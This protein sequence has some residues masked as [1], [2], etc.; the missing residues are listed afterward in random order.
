MNVPGEMAVK[1][2]QQITGQVHACNPAHRCNIGAGGCRFKTWREPSSSPKQP[3]VW[4]SIC[5]ASLQ[6]HMC[7]VG[8]CTEPG[9]QAPN[10]TTV[11]PISSLELQGPNEM[12]YAARTSG[13]G[14]TAKPFSHCMSS[15]DAPRKRRRVADGEPTRAALHSLLF[16]KQAV[17]L[18]Q[19]KRARGVVSVASCVRA[20][21]P[22]FM[23]QMVAARTQHP[24]MRAHQSHVFRLVKMLATDLHQYISRLRDRLGACKG[25]NALVAACVSY[26]STGLTCRG[27]AII[28]RLKWL[29]D[30][31]PH[32]SDYGKIDGFQSRPLSVASRC[33]K[34][35]VSGLR[36][37]P[38]STF[39]FYPR[40]V[41][42]SDARL[43]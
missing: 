41:L 32:P 39:C 38:D 40:L 25:H 28:P 26:L 3:A 14:S 16:S 29:K 7:G 27:V 30:L 15:M 22:S 42:P 31:A 23:A 10:G 5:Y 20:A 37:H 2:M 35:T 19:A 43:D 4:L 1:R 34:T 13:R 33:I 9:V 18:R 8:T 36:G 17:A 12:Y 21:G 6:Y 24:R 11:C